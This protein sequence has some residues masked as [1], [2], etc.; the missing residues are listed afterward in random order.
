MK[1]SKEIFKYIPG[2]EK[3]YSISNLGKVY[4]YFS[5]RCLTN[6]ISNNNGI[7]N[8]KLWDN[9]K[10][11]A[12]TFSVAK[13][14]AMTFLKN[15]NPKLYKYAI[16]KDGNFK[17][18]TLNNIE[19]GTSAMSILLKYKRHPEVRDK[20]VKGFREYFEKHGPP[21][22]KM[23]DQLELELLEYRTL[24]YSCFQLEEF[25]PIKKSQIMNIIKKHGDPIK[26]NL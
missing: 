17:N 13:L 15:P 24:G 18:L 21:T 25:F 23:N 20:F 22:K 7:Y 9:K 1:T 26:I 16:H 10:S 4:S 14:M 12:K 19:W 6:S 3:S 2:Y 8:V 5:H 11:K